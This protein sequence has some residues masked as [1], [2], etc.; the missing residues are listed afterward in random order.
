MKK[1]KINDNI[2][3]KLPKLNVNSINI[4]SDL[5][6]VE[7]KYLLKNLLKLMLI[8]YKKKNKKLNI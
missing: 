7:N 1:L 3:S 4:E 8:F 2:L 6:I 5:Y